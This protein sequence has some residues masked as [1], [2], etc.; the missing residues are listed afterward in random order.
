MEKRHVC[1]RWTE[2]EKQICLCNKQAKLYM[3]MHRKTSILCSFMVAFH[4][5]T[6]K[7]LSYLNESYSA[8]QNS[9]DGIEMS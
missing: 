9:T 2:G 6:L 4:F 8:H 7:V 1:S 5:D 3:V